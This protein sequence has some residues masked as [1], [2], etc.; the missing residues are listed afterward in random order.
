MLIHVKVVPNSKK[1]SVEKTNDGYRIKVDALPY[2]N[3]ANERLIQILAAHFA[4][5]KSSIRIVKGLHSRDKSI[6]IISI[7]VR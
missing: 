6:E 2:G 5:R 7:L 1:P 4:V 3:A